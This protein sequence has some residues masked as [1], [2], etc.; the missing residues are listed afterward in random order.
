MSG[1]EKEQGTGRKSIGARGDISTACWLDGR[2][3]WVLGRK[4]EPSVP[5]AT[6]GQVGWRRRSDG[7]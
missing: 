4:R 6:E 7:W 3:G 1:D 5:H 2:K